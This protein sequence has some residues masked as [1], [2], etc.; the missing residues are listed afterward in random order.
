MHGFAPV[1][2]ALALAQGEPAA[3]PSHAAEEPGGVEKP[4]S[5]EGPVPVEPVPQGEAPA[6]APAAAAPRKKRTPAATASPTPVVSKAVRPERSDDADAS[7][8]SRRAPTS[9]SLSAGATPTATAPRARQEAGAERSDAELASRA[10]LDALVAG[11]ADALAASASERFSFDGDTVA[12][13]DAIHARWRSLLAGR[14]G[15]APRIAK[16]EVLTAADALA[17]LG[18]P[19]GRIAPLARPGAYVAVADVGGRPV[20]LFVAREGGRF[21]VLGMHD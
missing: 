7:S 13:R 6:A 10:F 4:A 12:G 19:P 21:A 5:A 15:P 17:R 20:V 16:L 11:D 9:T 8:P 1:L 18:K 2:A 3:P 14:A